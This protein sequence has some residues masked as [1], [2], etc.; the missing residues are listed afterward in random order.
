MSSCDRKNYDCDGTLFKVYW[1]KIQGKWGMGLIFL[2]QTYFQCTLNIK[3]F[4]YLLFLCLAL[5]VFMLFL[6]YTQ[7]HLFVTINVLLMGTLLC[8]SFCCNPCE[9][10]LY[11]CVRTVQ[12]T[13]NQSSYCIFFH[14]RCSPIYP[15]II[16]V[17]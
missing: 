12:N 4:L 9:K 10:P 5:F 11:A 8:L 14:K 3:Y 6:L 17:I 15:T 13:F 2:V 1:K 7:L 16:F